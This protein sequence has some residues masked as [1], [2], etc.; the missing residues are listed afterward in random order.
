M[1]APCKTFHCL[2]VSEVGSSW[3]KKHPG[4]TSRSLGALPP[5]PPPSPW[6]VELLAPA[7]GYLI[8]GSGEK[9][10]SASRLEALTPSPSRC[11]R[12][13]LRN[14]LHSHLPLHYPPHQT[15]T[16]PTDP[17]APSDCSSHMHTIPRLQIQ[18]IR[19]RVKPSHS[20]SIIPRSKKVHPSFAIPDL[21]SEL[22]LHAVAR[23]KQQTRGA[24][25][26]PSRNLFPK[27]QV[28]LPRHHVPTPIRQH[29]HT[30]QMIKAQIASSA[31]RLR[32]GSILRMW[33]PKLP[34]FL[35]GI[36]ISGTKIRIQQPPQSDVSL[37]KPERQH[38]SGFRPG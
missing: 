27:R 3:Y 7:A 25:R 38:R 5:P 22:L 1:P 16:T 6:A 28:I 23:P 32:H 37:F 24:P 34:S 35:Q 9:Q 20:R 13:H 33:Q 19:S 29:P 17:P 30:A 4:R 18:Q 11:R 26:I 31:G 15:C 14:K 2:T 21:P 12:S 36:A 8:A 10:R